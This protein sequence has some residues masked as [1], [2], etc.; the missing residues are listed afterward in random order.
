MTTTTHT[1]AAMLFATGTQLV[2]LATAHKK[3]TG[4]NLFAL[5]TDLGNGVTFRELKNWL[6]DF[7]AKQTEITAALKGETKPVAKAAAVKPVAP[8]AETKP[9]ANKPAA[10]FTREELRNSELLVGRTK[11][12]ILRLV[13][14]ENDVRIAVTANGLR[15]PVSMIERNNRGNLRTVEGFDPKAASPR[16]VRMAAESANKSAAKVDAKPAAEVELKGTDVRDQEILIGRAKEKVIRVVNDH[17]INARVAVTDKGSRI[18]LANIER[19]NR[20]NLRVKLGKE[21]DVVK[22]APKATTPVKEGVRILEI[23]TSTNIAGASYEKAR[24]TLTVTF[25]SGAVYEYSGVTL[26]EIKELE[27]A[28][29]KGSHFSKVLK[30][31]KAAHCVVKATRAKAA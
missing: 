26:S 28:K 30:P 25:K 14:G 6:K 15:V 5:S 2:K 24:K 23:G 20:G 31:T 13:K 22:P 9:A 16:G 12:K 18:I 1:A 27:A 11:D 4:E 19:N 29:S 17:K 10:E 7:K 8:K 3:E 21:N